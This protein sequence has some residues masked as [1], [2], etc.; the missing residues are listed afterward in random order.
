MKAAVVV[1]PVDVTQHHQPTGRDAVHRD[2]QAAPP[3]APIDNQEIEQPAIPRRLN[4]G[5]RDRVVAWF[6][7]KRHT[8]QMHALG[9]GA[10]ADG[11]IP[12]GIVLDAV[13]VEGVSLSPQPAGIPDGTGPD[14]PFKDAR[15]W[16]AAELVAHKLNLAPR[17]PRPRHDPPQGEAAEVHGMPETRHHKRDGRHLLS[18]TTAGREANRR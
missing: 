18:I 11:L 6:P 10:A 12:A 14:P 9:V 3:I 2:L 17:L 1:L 5:L 4:I 16:T 13:P 8:V 15:A 7:L